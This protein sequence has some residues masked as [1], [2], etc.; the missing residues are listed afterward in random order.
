MSRS[1]KYFVLWLCVAALGTACQRKNPIEVNPYEVPEVIQPYVDLFEMEAAKRGYDITIDSLIVDFATDL[2]EGMAAGQCTFATIRSPI[3]H[4]TLDTTSFNWT[5][6]EYHR[7]ILVFHELGHCILDRRQHRDDL[8]P[9]GNISSIMRSTGEQVYGGSLNYFKREYYLDE[10]F[11][12]N[13]PAPDWATDF[14]AYQE[15]AT[16]TRTPILEEEFFDNQNDWATGNSDDFSARIADGRLYFESSSSTA[17]FN[18]IVVPFD[19]EQDFEIEAS[20]KVAGGASSAMLQWGGSTNATGRPTG[21]DLNFFGY[22]RDT[23]AFIG[24]WNTGVSI[25]NE[26]PAFRSGFNKLTIRKLGD[27]YHFYFNEVYFDVMEYESLA[28]E[29]FAFYV[30]PQTRIEVDYLRIYQLQR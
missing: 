6:N 30:G 28:G 12:V 1:L 29:V 9:N 16:Y 20:V 27:T 21:D 26:P 14:P 10:L 17:Y 18:P 3:P 4:I 7:E 15:G 2:N 5:N 22:A 24:T 13:T 23:T 11:D 19:E 8:L 25:G